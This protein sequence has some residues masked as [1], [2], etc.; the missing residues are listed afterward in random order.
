MAAPSS[1]AN[2][3]AP[4]EA[5]QFELTVERR[6]LRDVVRTV[7]HAICFHRVFGTVRPRTI[8]LF[9]MTFPAVQE[10]EID[11]MVEENA[12]SFCQQI[13]SRSSKRGDLL[14]FLL[15]PASTGQRT[16]ANH[17]TSSSSSSEAAPKSTAEESHTPSSPVS[18]A[19]KSLK[20]WASSK[21][22]SGYPYSWLAQA[23]SGGVGQVGGSHVPQSELEDAKAASAAAAKQK[24][25]QAEKERLRLERQSFET[26]RIRFDVVTARSERERIR[27][28]STTAMGMADFL[29]SLLQFVDEKK[30]H[31]P[32]IISADLCPFPIEIQSAVIQ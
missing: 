22:M 8:E 6:N 24:Q 5:F 2:V 21:T 32:A 12:A 20:S 14:V 26:W 30:A 16:A 17:T 3:G 25:E 23:F 28:Q 29:D 11:R 13:E 15:N 9:G 27:L 10:S 19:S 18:A 7:L 31:I 1:S 4:V